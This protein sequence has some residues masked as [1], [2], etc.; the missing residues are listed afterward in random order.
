MRRILVIGQSGQVGWE[1]CRTLQS[2]GEVVEADFGHANNPV[3]LSDH[4]SIRKLVETVDPQVIINAAAYTAVDKAET[5][6]DAAMA[7]NGTA[8][9]ILAEETKKRNALL[10]HYSTD[11]VFNGKHNKPYKEDDVTDPRSVY[12][13]TKL[14]GDQAIRQVGGKHLI[15]RTS[16]VYGLRG[17]NF[18]LTMRRLAAERDEM[19]VVSDQTGAPT[20]SRSIAEASAQVLAQYLSPLQKEEQSNL[21]GIYN[22]TCGGA[23]TWYDFACAIVKHENNAPRMIPIPT[24]EYPAPAPRPMYSVLAHEKLEDTFGLRLPDWDRALALCLEEA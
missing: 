6:Y 4:V 22:L 10:V 16:W 15:F 18:L 9:G 19:R 3:D 14:A 7:I 1:L 21:N 13:E 2:F 20:W 12:G 23:T 5:D 8:P 24:E 17:A 11:Y